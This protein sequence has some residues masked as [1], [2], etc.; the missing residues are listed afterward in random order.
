ML[1]SN[2]APVREKVVE[3]LQTCGPVT[4]LFHDYELKLA[5][6][7]HDF[8]PAVEQFRMLGSGSVLDDTARLLA[9]AFLAGV[10]F[11]ILSILV[12]IAA[13]L[14]F[15][16]LLVSKIAVSAGTAVVFVGMPLALMLWPIGM[17]SPCKQP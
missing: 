9:V 6:L 5:R 16:A 4:G 7:I 17:P 3:L 14:L 15:L 12:A 2:Y 13:A 11:N 10:A 1:G 8:M